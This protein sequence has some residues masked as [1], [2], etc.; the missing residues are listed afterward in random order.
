MTHAGTIDYHISGSTA[1]ILV[2]NPARRNAMSSVM[3]DQMASVIPILDSDESV[4]VIAVRGAGDTFVSGGD[5]SEYENNLAG[6][7]AQEPVISAYIDVF[8][9]GMNSLAALTKPLVA[10]ID[11]NCYGGGLLF[12]L[13]ADIRIASSRARFC[14]PAARLGLAYP[15]KYVRLFYE[16]VGP[17]VTAEVLFSSRVYTADQALQMRLVSQVVDSDILRDTVQGLLESIASS[18]P[19]SIAAMK[20]GLDL[21]RSEVRSGQDFVKVERLVKEC[22]DSEYF[23]NKTRDFLKGNR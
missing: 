14:V 16:L 6:A 18:S 20:A 9:R 11:G 13:L 15:Y 3:W 22:R 5:I 23:I 4:R 21:C 10:M 17:G 19:H 8:E 12:A 2:N 7:T 1:W